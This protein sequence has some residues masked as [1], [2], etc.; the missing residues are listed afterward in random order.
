MKIYQAYTAPINPPSASPILTSSQ[1]WQALVEKCHKP[2][3]FVLP[4]AD[5]EV[6]EESDVGLK[7]VVTFK[8]GMGPPAGK[9]TEV[10]TYH[11]QIM[12]GMSLTPQGL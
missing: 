5:C 8:P 11:G 9:V 3:K 6:L 2:Q 4:I 10:I 1:V 12:V 7:R